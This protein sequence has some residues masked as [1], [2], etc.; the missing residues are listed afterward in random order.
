MAEPCVLIVEPDILVRHPLAQYLRDCEFR[1]L[2]AANYQ[3]ARD[4]FADPDHGVDIV[5]ADVD[6]D[7]KTGFEFATWVRRTHPSLQVILT[8]TM[9]KTVE[10]AQTLCNDN[11]VIK[12]P[13]DHRHVLDHIKQLMAARDRNKAA[14]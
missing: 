1:V 3:E 8:A 6:H 14:D 9:S 12:K 11:P 5:L 2:I 4:H 13:L 7:D 10:K